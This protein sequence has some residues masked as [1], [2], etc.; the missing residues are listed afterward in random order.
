MPRAYSNGLYQVLQPIDGP[1]RFYQVVPCEPR[2]TV[3]KLTLKRADRDPQTLFLDEEASDGDV[4]RYFNVPLRNNSE[5]V[6]DFSESLKGVCDPE[7]LTFEWWIHYDHPAVPYP[8]VHPGVTG[9]DTPT[10]RMEAK[11]LASADGSRISTFRSPH[12]AGWRSREA[13]SVR[14]NATITDSTRLSP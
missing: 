5:L 10:L 6:L 4:F 2:V 12:P 7:R 9:Y 1:R 11:K 14:G 3:S 8:Y 13:A